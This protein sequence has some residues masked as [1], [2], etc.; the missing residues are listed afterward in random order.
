MKKIKLLILLLTG[1]ISFFSYSNVTIENIKKSDIKS[2]NIKEKLSQYDSKTI[3]ED[4]D[5]IL[6]D[7]E[8]NEY[9]TP[10]KKY[11]LKEKTLLLSKMIFMNDDKEALKNQVIPSFFKLNMCLSYHFRY[12]IQNRINNILNQLLNSEERRLMFKK[13]SDYVYS[14]KVNDVFL[15]Y[16]EGIG[17]EDISKICQSPLNLNT[18]KIGQELNFY[19][20]NIKESAN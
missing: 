18:L 11:L 2:Q 10:Y 13:S 8:N 15:E 16:I 17:G 19:N 3:I 14:K 9:L 7:I 5:K 12:N 4:I 20:E 6:L 1:F